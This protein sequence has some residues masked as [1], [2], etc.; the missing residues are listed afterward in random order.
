M[1]Y[2]FRLV[3]R[4]WTAPE[5][6]F[7]NPERAPTF[8]KFNKCEFWLEEVAFLDHIISKEGITVDL[9]K[10]EVVSKWKRPENLF[11]VSYG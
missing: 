10:V 8:V 2:T 5:N 1:P 9:S 4:S 7:I 3:I 6:G 11:V